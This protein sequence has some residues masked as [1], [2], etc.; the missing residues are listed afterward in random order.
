MDGRSAKPVQQF[1]ECGYWC[2][3]DRGQARAFVLQFCQLASY[4]LL[5]SNAICILGTVR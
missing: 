1:L 2:P 5:P 4:R 3:P